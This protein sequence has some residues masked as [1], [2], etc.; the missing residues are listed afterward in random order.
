L[1]FLGK[2]VKPRYHFQFMNE[3]NREKREQE[4]V[5]ACYASVKIKA[6]HKAAA[7]APHTLK[8]GDILVS[9]WGYEQA[10]VDFYQ[11]VGVKG[12]NVHLREIAAESIEATGHMSDRVIALKDRFVGDVMVK[13]ANGYNHVKMKSYATAT[14]YDGRPHHRSW[15]A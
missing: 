9:S 4:F 13:R 15:Y 11:V 3:A 14:P 6:E 1:A 10:N 5:S 7:N 8:E 2:S 12:R